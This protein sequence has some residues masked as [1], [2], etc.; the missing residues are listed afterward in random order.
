MKN[1]N[2]QTPTPN[3]G[4]GIECA[5]RDMSVAEQFRRHP[6]NAAAIANALVV[7]LG[8][9]LLLVAGNM[10][11]E[12]VSNTGATV[13]ASGGP[14]TGEVLGLLAG[15]AWGFAPP[16]LLAGW[17]TLVLA[18]R[19]L[20]AGRGDWR[21]VAEAGAAGFGI[22]LLGLARG[23]LTRPTE[24]LPYVIAYGGIALIIGLLVG[25]LLRAVA[26]FVLRRLED[27]DLRSAHPHA[28]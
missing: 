17:R 9:V 28:Q 23:I 5:G 22:A 14:R 19:W 16:A 13:R 2:A 4:A 7:L 21:G 26:L 1:A 20:V 12:H 6:E 3:P 10:L 18:R 27:A 8:P 11:P 15:V 24:A 25:L